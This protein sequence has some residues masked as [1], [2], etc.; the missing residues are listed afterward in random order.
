MAL[1]F[2]I[3]QQAFEVYACN[4]LNSL[5]PFI[6]HLQ[7]FNSKNDILEAHLDRHSLLIM[8]HSHKMPEQWIHIY[9]SI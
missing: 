1:S 9:N 4:T 7:I 5:F 8:Q 2:A 6:E 3:F